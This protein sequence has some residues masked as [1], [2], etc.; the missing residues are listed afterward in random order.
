MKTDTKPSAKEDSDTLFLPTSHF[1]SPTS[2]TP[3]EIA[4]IRIFL[5]HIVEWLRQ[6]EG[7]KGKSEGGSKENRRNQLLHTSNF[8]A[9]ISNLN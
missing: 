2:M 3:S 9:P 5:P 1:R 4:A 7:G 6:R 8:R